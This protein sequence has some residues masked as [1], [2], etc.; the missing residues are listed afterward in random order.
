MPQESQWQGTENTTLTLLR[1]GH[2]LKKSLLE[3]SN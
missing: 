2:L 3:E 1:N